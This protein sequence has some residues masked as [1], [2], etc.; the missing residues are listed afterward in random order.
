MLHKILKKL[1][2]KPLIKIARNSDSSTKVSRVRYLA[3]IYHYITVATIHTSRVCIKIITQSM[4]GSC[5]RKLL[6]Q[7]AH[8]VA[9]FFFYKAQKT[10]TCLLDQF[11]LQDQMQQR[12]YSHLQQQH[13]QIKAKIPLK[14]VQIQLINSAIARETPLPPEILINKRPKS[15]YPIVKRD[16]TLIQ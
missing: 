9:I 5:I 13:T 14:I 3:Q 16:L 7:S 8:K 6:T 2:Y 10:A 15:T 11:K 12:L 4:Q 1:P